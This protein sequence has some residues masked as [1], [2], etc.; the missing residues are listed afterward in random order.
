MHPSWPSGRLVPPSSRAL[1]AA[2]VVAAAL[3]ATAPHRGHGRRRPACSTSSCAQRPRCSEPTRLAAALERRASAPLLVSLLNDLTGDELAHLAADDTTWLDECGRVFVADHAIPPAQQVTADG[4]PGRGRA[5]RRL[6]P[7]LATGLDAHDLP[8]LRRRDLL[9]HPV[10][11]RRARSCRRPTRSTPTARRSAT[12]ERA[13][14]YLAWRTVAEDFAPFD[15]NVTTQRPDPSALTRTTSTDQTYGIPVVVTPT[16][17]VGSG[18]GCGGISYIG[19]FGTVGATAYQ[20]AWI[21]TVGLGHRRLRRRPDHQP[22]GRPHLRPEPRR[23]Q[24]G[25][26]YYAGAKGWAPIMGSSYGRRASHWSSGEYAGANNPEDDTAVIARTAPVAR[27]RPRQ[28][29]ARRHP[30]H[31]GHAGRG[32]RSPRGPT[33]TRS[34]SARAAGTALTVAGPRRA[35]QPRRA[36][37]DPR[38]AR[39]PRSPPSTRRPT[40]PTTRRWRRPGPSTC[41]ATAATYVAVVDG[42]GFGTPAEAGRYSDYGSL[43]AYAVD[44]VDRRQHGHAADR[45]PPTTPTPPPRRPRRQRTSDRLRHHAAAARARAGAR[46]TAPPSGS[47]ARCR[48]HASTGGCRGGC[49]G[50]SSATAS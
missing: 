37:D 48:R 46:P 47:G 27:R 41:R 22:R 4:G 33:P 11:E 5:R 35:L 39:A 42:T 21:F 44:A 17:S 30:P 18:C 1:A 7:L 13:Q 36:A 34:P 6:R 38:R 50:R 26:R 2:A 28:R 19:I 20:P 25:A 9:R 15:V 3:T 49:G 12:T 14:I 45:P 16:N 31:R 10:E 43:G 40:S 23:H 32:R 24:P 29:R 8:R